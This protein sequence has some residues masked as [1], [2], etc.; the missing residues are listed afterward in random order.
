MLFIFGIIGSMHSYSIDT[1]E[2]KNFIFYLALFSILLSWVFFKILNNCK[3]T[4]PWWVESPSVLF[5]YGLI[6]IIFDKWCWKFFKKIGIIKTPNLYGEWEGYL[7]SSFNKHSSEI[8][9]TLKIIQTW[10]KIKISLTTEQSISQSKTASFLINNH[11]EKYLYYQYI[12]EPRQYANKKMHIH[13]GTTKLY[14]DKKESILN[15]EYYSGRD[16]RNFGILY[17]KKLNK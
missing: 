13:Y 4:F 9:A 17:F 5:F 15:G 16:R 7:K 12:N 14:L 8:K 10:T 2:R 1:E 6:F 11:E 3:I